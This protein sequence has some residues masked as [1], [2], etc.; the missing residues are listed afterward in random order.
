MP[1]TRHEPPIIDQPT[2]ANPE[3]GFFERIKN[4]VL[5][6][7]I[8]VL[9]TSLGF[10]FG[11]V[12]SIFAAILTVLAGLLLGSVAGRQI[13]RAVALKQ[14]PEM[15]VVWTQMRRWRYGDPRDGG[16]EV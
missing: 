13:A 12:G 15:Q 10:L 4:G 6:V 3:P 7:I 1:E 14:K 16:R 5:Y 11:L 2:A 8:M 9:A